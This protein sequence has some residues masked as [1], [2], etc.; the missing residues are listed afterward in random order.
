MAHPV[1][2][3][4]NAARTL[5][6]DIHK[7]MEQRNRALL[8][9][10]MSM[11]PEVRDCAAEFGQTRADLSGRPIPI[12]GVAGDQQPATVGQPAFG[13]NVEIHVWN[14]LFCA[15]NTGSTAVASQN[16]LL[17]TIAYQLNGTPTCAGRIHIHCGAVVQWLRDGLGLS[18]V[19]VILWRL[20]KT[21]I[22]R[23][24]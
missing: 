15:L 14:R 4:T 23:R 24:S 16:R 19:P 5:L 9:I 13:R 6:Y 18:A 11:L 7:G 22:P 8:D 1:T 12:Y 10:P 3:A 21:L 17:T 20:P 2:D